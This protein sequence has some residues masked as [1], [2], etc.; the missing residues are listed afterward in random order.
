MPFSLGV[1]DVD[2]TAFVA[3]HDRRLVVEDLLHPG[4]GVHARP[5]VR[6]GPRNVDRLVEFGTVEAPAV[7]LVPRREEI[8]ERHG[9]VVVGPPAG[10]HQVEVASGH[11]GEPL[12]ED[13]RVDLDVDA[14]LL[15]VEVLVVLRLL[16]GGRAVADQHDQ[17]GRSVE[18]EFLDRQR[19]MAPSSL[20]VGRR[21]GKRILLAEVAVDA[22]QPHRKEGRARQVP[23]Q[24]DDPVHQLRGVVDR[25]DGLAQVVVAGQAILAVVELH[26]EHRAVAEPLDLPTPLQGVVEVLRHQPRQRGLVVLEKVDDRVRVRGEVGVVDGVQA[27]A[28]CVPVLRILLQLNAGAMD[29][30]SDRERAVVEQIL[31]I[32]GIAP[33]PGLVER[34]VD[35]V[36]GRERH[37]LVEIGNG[38]LQVNLERP[39]VN[40]VHT[41]FFQRHLAP[42]HRFRVLQAVEDERVF[43]GVARVEHLAPRENEVVR[44]DRFPVAPTGFGT[45]PERRRGIADLPIP[46]DAAD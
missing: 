17:R 24:L 16:L 37:Q 12:L 21:V 34:L 38:P 14:E 36:V 45:K 28:V 7:V 29:P 1:G 46:R 43:G 4:H 19:K 3:D 6:R 27:D 2:R 40:G 13:L 42:V 18:A 15:L 22:L 30:P 39:V 20:V 44:G 8:G 5:G 32:G 23:W 41:E 10:H 11:L 33:L 31:G 26:E 25:L 9:I 35:R